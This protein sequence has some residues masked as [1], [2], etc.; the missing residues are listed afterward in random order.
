MLLANITSRYHA[1]LWSPAVLF[2][3]CCPVCQSSCFAGCSVLLQLCNESVRVLCCHVA[4]LTV[5]CKHTM[6]FQLVPVISG[7][8]AAHHRLLRCCQQALCSHGMSGKGRCAKYC[9]LQCVELVSLPWRTCVFCTCTR[10][11][12]PALKDCIQ[13]RCDVLRLQ[14]VFQRMALHYVAAPLDRPGHG[15]WLHP[16]KMGWQEQTARGRP[17]QLVVLT[18]IFFSLCV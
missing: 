13:A 2:C 18:A 14:N 7:L 6:G 10:R 12:L 8:L 1:A 11:V 4:W 9:Y 3:Q 5:R 16:D 15:C 17:C